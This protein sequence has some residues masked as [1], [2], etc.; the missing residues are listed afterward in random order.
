MMVYFKEVVET[1]EKYNDIIKNTLM[2]TKL[3]KRMKN[4][5]VE[6]VLKLQKR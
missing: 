1:I 6:L 2:V 4:S 5:Y 3:L